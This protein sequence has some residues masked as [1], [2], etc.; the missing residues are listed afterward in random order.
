[1]K[2]VIINKK[3]DYIAKCASRGIAEII[4]NL[5]TREVERITGESDH[6]TIIYDN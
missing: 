4:L 6:F 2:H 1:M 3:G 5:L